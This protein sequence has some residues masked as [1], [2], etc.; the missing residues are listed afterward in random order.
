MS[1]DEHLKRLVTWML[2]NKYREYWGKKRFA[3][4]IYGVQGVCLFHSIAYNVIWFIHL[5]EFESNLERIVSFVSMGALLWMIQL[6]AHTVAIF[7]YAQDELLNYILEFE[8]EQKISSNK[9][10]EEGNGEAQPEDFFRVLRMIELSSLNVGGTCFMPLA[11][12]S[13][14]IALVCTAGLLDEFTTDGGIVELVS[15]YT[16]F[17]GILTAAIYYGSRI[18][19]TFQRAH[20]GGQAVRSIIALRN[21]GS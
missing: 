21:F 18:T 20:I 15:L 12:G 3:R 4:T 8:G 19:T 16:F 11:C 6:T 7:I 5:G 9:Q 10:W 13:A 2:A 17:S 1:R 14:G